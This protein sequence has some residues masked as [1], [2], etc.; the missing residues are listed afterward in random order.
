MLHVPYSGSALAIN[1]TV[2]GQTQLM[3][4][5]LFTAM[6]FVKAASSRQ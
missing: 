3:F 4:P 1:H 2:A 6:N 5:S